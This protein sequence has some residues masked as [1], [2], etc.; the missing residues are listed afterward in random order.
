MV[1]TAGAS[2]TLENNNIH[3]NTLHGVEVRGEGSEAVLRGNRIHDGEEQGV[4]IFEGASATLKNNNMNMDTCEV[5][6][7]CTYAYHKTNAVLR[8]DRIYDGKTLQEWFGTR[9]FIC[10]G[11][12][13]TFENNNILGSGEV[14]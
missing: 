11:A 14:T 1:I 5:L 8:G 10:E 7:H 9:V 13:A 6:H 12:S 4:F 3:S 2:V